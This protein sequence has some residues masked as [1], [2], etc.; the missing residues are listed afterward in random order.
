MARDFSLKIQGDVKTLRKRLTK[1]ERKVI[2]SAGVTTL[3]TV[4]RK[5]TGKAIKSVA[6]AL[7]VQQKGLRNKIYFSKRRQAARQKMY[8]DLAI[9]RADINAAS[10]LGPKRKEQLIKDEMLQTGKMSL[11]FLRAVQI[12]LLHHHYG[13]LTAP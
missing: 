5:A 9:R 4:A 13:C 7:G 2:P 8:A 1:L 11:L 10:M 12:R 3:N 6:S